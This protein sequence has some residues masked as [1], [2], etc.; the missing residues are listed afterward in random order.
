MDLMNKNNYIDKPPSRPS[1]HVFTHNFLPIHVFTHEKNH[2]QSFKKVE[3]SILW[4]FGVTKNL[5]CTILNI[6]VCYPIIKKF[7]HFNPTYPGLFWSDE[8]PGGGSWGPPP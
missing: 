6:L 2:Y 3:F 8:T 4:S 1:I 5:D 7:N